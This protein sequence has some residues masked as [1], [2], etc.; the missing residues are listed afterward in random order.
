MKLRDFWDGVDT[1]LAGNL[2]TK[3][4]AHRQA[5]NV[6]ILQPNALRANFLSLTIAIGI[7]ATTRGQYDLCL[8]RIIRLVVPRQCPSNTS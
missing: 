8:L 5:W 2:I 7:D 4:A 3:G 1:D 6:F